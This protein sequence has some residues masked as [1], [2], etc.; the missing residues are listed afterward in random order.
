MA[1]LLAWIVQGARAQPV[2]L[3]I[4]D[5]HWTDSASEELLGKIV[6]GDSKL[7]L[8]YQSSH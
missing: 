8:L 3:A 5:L 7:R 2:V 6:G 4:E 1:A